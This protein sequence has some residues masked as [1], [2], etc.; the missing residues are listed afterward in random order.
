M[1]SRLFADGDALALL[2]AERATL[3]ASTRDTSVQKSILDKAERAL[4]D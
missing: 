1:N 2:D 3:A 4:D